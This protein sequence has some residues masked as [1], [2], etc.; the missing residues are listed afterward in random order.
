MNSSTRGTITNV[1]LVLPDGMLTDMYR[2]L[3]EDPSKEYA[4][5]LLCG[6][7]RQEKTLYLLGCSMIY[8]EPDEYESHALT[9]V[10]LKRGLLISILSECERLGLSLID[11]HSHP[12]STHS[13]NFSSIDDADE[14]EKA[15]WFSKHLPKCYY[16][17][18]VVAKECHT[19][20]I[21]SVAGNQVE[22]PLNIRQVSCPLD[23]RS[24]NNK[25][26]RTIGTESVYKRQ[27]QA[28]GKMGQDRIAKVRV[29]IVG[30]GG[31]G[32]GLAIN[33][34]RLGI[35]DFTL[36]DHDRTELHNLNRLAGMTRTDGHLSTLKVD[37]VSREIWN[38][39]TKVRIKRIASMVQSS[40]VWKKL[41][42]TD[43][44]ISATDNHASRM[45][46][47]AISQQYLV[48]HVSIGTLI[49]SKD[50]QLTDACGHVA[51]S[52][53]AVGRP[54]LMC[55]KL[56]DPVEAYYETAS[57]DDR[58]QAAKSGYIKNFEER[59][60]A[61]VHLNGV[62]L[63]LALVEIHN[64]VHGFKEYS[65]YLFYDMLEQQ[66][67]SVSMGDDQCAVCGA[68]GGYFGRGDLAGKPNIFNDINRHDR[69][70][71]KN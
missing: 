33:L 13:V 24:S 51:V 4:C 17:S 38:I 9:S 46:L 1:E 61:V 60:P 10:K 64:L 28:F 52:L 71:D 53:P 11:I 42:N 15:N 57:P 34:A 18:I 37:V 29:G 16:G 49:E 12:F 63:N 48:P 14:V 3:F 32:A 5:Y 25:T 58:R 27:I 21:R 54:C 65:P 67:Y 39:D 70:K 62:I 47:N 22:M 56:I 68:G 59:E 20:R 66:I 2:Y 30:L 43:I 44:I 36:V 50:N 40:N 23:L 45:F 19:A 31:L 6:H 55:A 8:P 41:L 7:R 26:S 35:R 69:N